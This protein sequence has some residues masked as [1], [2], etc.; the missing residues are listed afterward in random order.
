MCPGHERV[1]RGIY[2]GGNSYLKGKHSCRVVGPRAD[3][4]RIPLIDVEVGDGDVVEVGQLRFRVFDTPGMHTHPY[5][6]AWAYCCMQ[7]CG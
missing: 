1:Q 6:L 3:A 7:L 5:S 4:A 2:A